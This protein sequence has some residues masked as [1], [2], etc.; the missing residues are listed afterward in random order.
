MAE[1]QRSPDRRWKKKKKSWKIQKTTWNLIPSS[2]LAVHCS[3]WL[4]FLKPSECVNKDRPM[5]HLNCVI[6]TLKRD[7]MEF[8]SWASSQS[9]LKMPTQSWSEFGHNGEIFKLFSKLL[10]V[11]PLR[12][13][14]IGHKTIQ[15]NLSAFR[16]E[17]AE[18]FTDTI[19]CLAHIFV[20]FRKVREKM[21]WSQGWIFDD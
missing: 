19:C 20:H 12:G 9:R 15:S 1:Q 2:W 7:Q 13:Y 6:H 4:E 3:P 5:T 14:K 17:C 11:F 18:K 10:A 8:F 21:Y 16:P